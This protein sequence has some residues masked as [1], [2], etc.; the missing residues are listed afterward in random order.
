[1]IASS[2]LIAELK[3]RGA[4]RVALQAPEGLKRRL[5]ELALDLQSAGFTVFVS[6]DPCYGACDLDIDLLK[7]ADLLIHLG[8]APVDK[9]ERILYDIFR[10]DFDPEVVL[11]A[12]PYFTTG[13]IGLVT[14]VQ[15]AH[16]IPEICRILKEVGISVTVAEGSDRTPYPGQILG[17]S[18][19]A[20]RRT[21]ETE[22]LYLGTGVFHP[23]GVQIAT[24]AKVIACDPYTKQ[25]E[26]VNGERLLRRRYALIEKA[27][28]AEK[29]GILVSPKSG[30]ARREL[31]AKLASLSPKAILVQLREVTPDQ[32]LNLGLPCYVNTAC[33][34][35]AY[36]DQVRWPVPVLTPQEFEILCGVRGF[37][38]YEVDEIK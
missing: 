37:E 28:P 13:R 7:D 1:M 34:R 2:D 38:D 33:P 30:Q 3:Q 29:I 17:C 36:D 15:H 16:L 27:K 4:E 10:M 9:T 25:I 14:T 31:A 24:G 12:I 5:P 19:E 6:G 32:L 22:I 26:E 11:N 8:H 23:L 20:A 35:L 18:F 21:G